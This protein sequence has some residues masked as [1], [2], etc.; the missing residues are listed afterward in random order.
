[1]TISIIERAQ[2]YITHM[3]PSIQ[4]SGGSDA[5]YKVALSLAKGFFLPEREAFPI[6]SEWNQTN[7]D[8]PWSES[9]LLHKLRDASNS[10][11][12]PD[13]YLLKDQ[14]A[15]KTRAR[16]KRVPKARYFLAS[17]GGYSAADLAQKAA[18]QAAWTPLRP[19]T[20]GEKS[21]IAAL[22]HCPG[23][24]VDILSQ[25]DRLMADEDRPGCFILTDGRSDGRGHRQYRNLNGSAFHHG[26][27]SDNT[28][29]SAAKG[30]FSL[31]HDRRLDPDELI[32]ITEGTISLL[33]SI[34]IQWLCEGR[35]NRW[36]FLAAHS[37]AST[38][39]AEPKILEAIAGHHCR[40]MPDPGETGTDAAKAWR[41]ELRALGCTVD[42]A[43]L[44]DGFQDLK[45][46]LAAGS[47]G[48]A[49]A[50]SLLAYPAN[51][52]GGQE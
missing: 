6:L 51:R 33:E 26:K 14:D 41:N 12:V 39:A 30:F 47:D 48:F 20:G 17:R 16:I 29:G 18:K 45:T 43:R 40:I 38:F 24:A 32:F 4:G 34:S 25:C 13:R 11:H 36:H 19:L 21:A 27:K 23:A 3:P 22:R 42:R 10:T 7:A 37:A 35:A 9:E 8:P 52:K 28:K 2:R 50:R 5:I 44:P 49:A 31:S 15:F 46:I 1:M